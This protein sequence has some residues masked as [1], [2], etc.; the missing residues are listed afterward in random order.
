MTQEEFKIAAQSAGLDPA[1]FEESFT[2]S[3]GPGG[4]NVN[5][6]ST[7]VILVHRPTGVSVRVEESRSQA[8]NRTLARQRILEQI[9]QRRAQAAQAR[10]HEREKK[11][12]QNAKRPRGVKERIL[13]AKKKRSTLKQNRRSSRED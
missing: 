3:S 6:V 12:R 13:Q 7:A 10:K 9:Q 4:Q 2:H 8:K 5:K 1:D 11:R